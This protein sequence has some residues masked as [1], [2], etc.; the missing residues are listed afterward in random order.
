MPGLRTSLYLRLVLF[1]GANQATA[2]GVRFAKHYLFSLCPVTTNDTNFWFTNKNSPCFV[3]VNNYCNYWVGNF[4]FEKF[5]E[6]NSK[7]QRVIYQLL[8]YLS[9]NNNPWK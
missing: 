9:K 4:I 3:T 2:A 1:I 5:D 8:K 6:P 7:S